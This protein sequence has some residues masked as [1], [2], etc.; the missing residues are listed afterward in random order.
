M[1]E[2]SE[3]KEIEIFTSSIEKKDLIETIAWWLFTLAFD[4]SSNYHNCICLDL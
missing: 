3:H 1:R 2:M 4:S